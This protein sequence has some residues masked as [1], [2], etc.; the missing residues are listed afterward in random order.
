MRPRPCLPAL[1]A[2]VAAIFGTALAARSAAQDMLPAE[3]AARPMIHTDA[4]RLRGCG[5]KM[6]A[7]YVG[8]NLRIVGV[9]VFVSVYIDGRGAF[10]G[11]VSEFAVPTQAR[12]AQSVPVAVESIWV[13]S[14][15]SAATLPVLGKVDKGES[16]YSLLYAIEGDSA[17]ALMLSGLKGETILFGFKRRGSPADH[18][19]AGIPKLAQLEREQ[20]QHCLADLTR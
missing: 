18:I 11:E 16:G 9:E 1:L 12:A 3:V 13:K 5:L 2:L 7:A 4:G 20:L 15:D 6:F 17:I 14:P 8:S 19:Y 10:E